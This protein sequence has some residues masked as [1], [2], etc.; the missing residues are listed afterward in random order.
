MRVATET[1]DD[2]QQN[3]LKRWQCCYILSGIGQP[4]GIAALTH[5]LKDQS[6]VVRGV[7]ACALGTFDHPTARA[8]LQQALANESNTNVQDAIQKA[9]RGEYKKPQN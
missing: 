8:A 2:L 3:M 5:A 1:I 7:A 6:S 9:L 4:S